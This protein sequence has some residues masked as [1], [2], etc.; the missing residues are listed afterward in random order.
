MIEK[1]MITTVRTRF[2]PSPTGYLHVGSARTALYAYL[3][4][5]RHQGVFILRVEDTDI[6]RSTQ[7]SVDTILEGMEWLGLHP[8]EGPFYQT[9]RFERYKEIA[10]ELLSNQ[11]AYKCYCSKERLTA[12]REKQTQ[13]KEKP[14][15]DGLCRNRKDHPEDQPY[16]IRFANPIDGEVIFEDAVHKKTVFKNSELDDLII[17][18]SDGAPTYNFCVVVDDSD[19]KIT[20]VIR[21]DDHLNNTP[22]QIN[23]LK[24]LGAEIPVYAH[25]PMI[26]GSDG[27]KFS[28]RH[29]AVSVIQYREEGFLSHAL[30]NYLV[31]LGWSHGDQE[32]FSTQQ[33]TALFDIYD[34]NKAAAA[35]NPSKLIWLNQH[36]L[37]SGSIEEI[38][39][40]F[41]WHCE[42][43]NIDITRGP[44]LSDIFLIQRERCKTLKEMAER[45]EFFYK[46]LYPSEALQ[47]KHITSEI[48]KILFILSQKLE[49][50][51][52][53]DWTDEALHQIIH[54]TAEQAGLK[55]GDLAQP[56]RII[57]SGGIVSPTLNSTMRIIGKEKVLEKLKSYA[58]LAT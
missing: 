19:M 7:E 45:S 22:R 14:R 18:R 58:L 56:I 24:A 25:I 9:Q 27:K 55:L 2:A 1:L 39:P 8:D 4:A 28:K 33:M 13:N 17:V 48:K 3:Y 15:Y 38:L 35:F 34:V 5:K 12:L 37:K 47:Q 26:L 57:L 52:D 32:I 40:E 46:N 41:Q 10:Q 30:L 54:H 6:E 44:S 36:Y 16:V 23:I 51:S 29:G 31:R 50:L 42:R 43:L 20:H 49:N 11:K 53:D 21:G